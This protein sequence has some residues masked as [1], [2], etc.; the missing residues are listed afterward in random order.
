MGVGR[1]QPAGVGGEAAGLGGAVRCWRSLAAGERAGKLSYDV[2]VCVL[3]A[4][5]VP[6]CLRVNGT[7]LRNG[8]RRGR[9]G[10]R[11]VRGKES[12]MAKAK[13]VSGLIKLQIQAGAA[14]PA[15]PV[16]PA[17]GQHGVNIMEFCKAYNAA[18]E[19][20][21]GNVVPVE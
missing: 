4:V 6:G 17:L 12:I 13:K 16:G 10:N 19:N 15:P 1:E 21:R 20:Q 3:S 5:G 18:T 2:V 11:L 9:A 14:N 7:A 8:R